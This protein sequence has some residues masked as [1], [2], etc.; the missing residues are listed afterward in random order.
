MSRNLNRMIITAM[1]LMAALCLTV[2]AGAETTVSVNGT[3]STYLAADIAYI[4]LG[5]RERSTNVKEA[6]NK[7]NEAIGTVRDALLAA[8]VK[9]ENINTDNINIYTYDEYTDGQQNRTV[10]QASS[11]LCIRT[12]DMDQ[13]GPII[14]TAF[15]SGANTLEGVSFSASDT[16]TERDLSLT[17]AV[18]DARK[19][20]EV[21]AAASGL[22][23]TGVVSVTEGYTNSYDSGLNNFSRKYAAD[24]VAEAEQ[25][26]G[27]LVQAA[28]LCVTAQVTVVFTA[29]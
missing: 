7:V 15:A 4:T 2:S 25:V 6:Q 1:C 24:T 28:K 17:A 11:M 3:G 21:L 9:E 5:V 22:K 27:T 16:S 10:Y 14:D 18:T 13:V 29:E 26:A 23:I 19:K 20:A 8:G 12:E